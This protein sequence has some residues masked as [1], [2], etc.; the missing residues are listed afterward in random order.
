M[1]AEEVTSL[2]CRPCKSAEI[3]YSL[4]VPQGAYA[5]GQTLRYKLMIHNGSMTDIKGYRLDFH[6]QMTFTALEP[7]RQSRK[8]DVIVATKRCT[9]E[10]CPKLSHRTF[11][12]GLVLPAI[13]PDTD[14]PEEIVSV[15]HSLAAELIYRGCHFNDDIR[16][17][18]VIGTMPIR[19]GYTPSAPSAPSDTMSSTESSG[20]VHTYRSLAPSAPLVEESEDSD[21]LPPKYEGSIEYLYFYC[22][23]Y[24]HIEWFKQAYLENILITFEQ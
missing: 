15:T 24:P 2:C 11:E 19:E 14:N 7:E 18:I 10:T 20:P 3:S 21:D 16:I 6:E 22:K 23:I 1:H 8:S 12:G 13:P 9:T 4:E 17:P 5:S